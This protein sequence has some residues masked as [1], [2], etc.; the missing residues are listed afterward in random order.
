MKLGASALARGVMTMKRTAILLS[1]LMLTATTGTAFAAWVPLLI[2][3]E[4]ATLFQAQTAG[5]SGNVKAC[6]QNTVTIQTFQWTHTQT[7]NTRGT[8]TETTT[9]DAVQVDNSLCEPQ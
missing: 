9:T 1:A 4:T 5:K 2:N 8:F 3:E 6:F 7:G